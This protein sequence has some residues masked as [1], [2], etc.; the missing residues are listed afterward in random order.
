MGR[1]RLWAANGEQTKLY[2]RVNTRSGTY[3][4]RMTG[5]VAKGNEQEEKLTQGEL[6]SKI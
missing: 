1:E 6:E 4:I 3:V 5:S 2:S